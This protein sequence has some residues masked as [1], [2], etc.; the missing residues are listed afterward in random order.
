MKKLMT[1]I[2]AVATAFGLFAADTPDPDTYYSTS[3]E[4]SDAGC[5]DGETFDWETAGWTTTYADGFTLATQDSVL[6]YD[7]GRARRDEFFNAKDTNNKYLVL[8]TGTNEIKHAIGGTDRVFFDQLVKFTGYEDA[9]TIADGTKIAVWLSATETDESTVGATNLYV[10]AGTGTT[11][12]NLLIAGDYTPDTWYRLTIKS[13]GNV[14]DESTSLQQ[15]GFLVYINGELA[16]IVEDQQDYHANPTKLIDPSGFYEKGQLFTAIDTTTAVLASVGYAGIGGV[17]DIIFSKDAPDFAASV[18]VTVKSIDGALIEVKD[19]EGKTIALTDGHYTLPRGAFTV[20]YTAADGYILPGAP[21]VKPYNTEVTTKVNDSETVKPQVVVVE[22][23]YDDTNTV[24]YAD[25]ASALAAVEAYTDI[26]G[27]SVAVDFKQGVTNQ[28]Y[29][30]DTGT[31][32][33]IYDDYVAPEE[34]AEVE[35]IHSS[36]DITAGNVKFVTGLENNKIVTIDDDHVLTFAGTM[37]A[38]SSITAK[39]IVAEANAIALDPVDCFVMTLNNNLDAAFVVPTGYTLGKYTSEDETDPFYGWTTYNLEEVLPV[40]TVTVESEATPFTNVDEALMYVEEYT[41]AHPDKAV[42]VTFNQAVTKEGE[43][44]FAEGATINITTDYAQVQSGDQITT[45]W[46][47]AGGDAS[48]FLPVGNYKDVTLQVG[49]TLTFAGAI[50]EGSS[51][52][53]ETLTVPTEGKITLA[54]TAEVKTGSTIAE[55]KFEVP[56][57]YKLDVDE[58]GGLYTYTC[59]EKSTDPREAD[60]KDDTEVGPALDNL[61]VSELAKENIKTVAEFNAFKGYFAAKTE[62]LSWDQVTT[63]QKANAYLCYALDAAAIPSKEITDSDVTINSFANGVIEIAI[64]GVVAGDEVPAAM[65]AKVI[66]VIGNNALTEMTAEK[67]AASGQVTANGKV[68]VTV[69]PAESIEDKSKFFY[70][71]SVKK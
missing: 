60:P 53:A 58:D 25:A 8:E 9:P 26:P 2:A 70:R 23:N 65:I 3:F 61:G 59:V 35:P 52:T 6:P 57:G 67:V 27:N 10:T 47:L 42:L 63:T 22:V 38:G 34:E 43:Y 18:N 5:D 50:G 32:I 54:A 69:A 37:K 48:F 7:T 51:V 36:W 71:A 1:M 24:A 12:T 17:D 44:A 49:Y 15:A 13:L 64:D 40:V 46:S 45:T 28:F 31:K 56:T 16:T 19:S 39:T 21:I 62:G 14:I 29:A 20:T 41:K 11:A 30:F 4:A 66:D 55:E 68:Q 33:S